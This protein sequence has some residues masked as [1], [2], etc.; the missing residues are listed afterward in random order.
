MWNQGFHEG[1]NHT[2]YKI[3]KLS[4]P[5]FDHIQYILSLISNMILR[6]IHVKNCNTLYYTY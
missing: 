6:I 3:P 2:T 4:P 1:I 5:L